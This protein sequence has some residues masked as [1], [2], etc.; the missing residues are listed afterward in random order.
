MVPE[1][2][3]PTDSDLASQD[4]RWRR[5]GGHLLKAGLVFLGVY[6]TWRLL[7][8][9]DWSDLAAR[10][11]RASWPLLA[12]ATA[13]L[14][15]RYMLW[16]WRFR[17]AARRVVPQIPRAGL[18]F[19]ILMA[20]AA[21][22]LITPSARLIGGLVRA[23]YFAHALSRS[24]GQLYGVVLY[25]QVAHHVVMSTCTG[26]ALVA[27]ALALGRIDV[28]VGVLAV[29]AAAA[30]ALL[31]WS[32][33]GGSFEENP[34]VR[35][36]A[37]RAARAEGRA[38]RFYVHGHEA[39]GI[40][41]RLLAHAPLHGQAAVLGLGFFLLNAAAQWIVFLALGDRTSPLVALAG[42]SLGAAAGMLTGTPGGLGTTEAAMVASFTAMGMDPVDAAAGSL[43][44]RGLHYASI[45]AVGLPALA[46][47]EVW[48][49]RDQRPP[50]DD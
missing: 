29:L 14:L 3:P 18:G 19:S 28:A 50:D 40:F 22:N 6:F 15:G 10:M 4:D 47:L 12:L 23:R 42:V 45:L 31:A 38:Q 35:F 37:R 20:S 9:I 16:D 27:A 41:L 5:W 7:S 13:V 30:V 46:A 1:T 48:M 32:R 43:L 39:V 44:F 2:T 36:L 26:L 25:D 17:L 49:G 34:L 8:G 24:F 11:S 21:L 33:R